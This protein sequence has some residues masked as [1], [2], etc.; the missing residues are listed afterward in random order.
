MLKWPSISRYSLM[1]KFGLKLL[2]FLIYFLQNICPYSDWPKL[3]TFKKITHTYLKEE[4]RDQAG[5]VSIWRS[6]P[7]HVSV[8][9]ALAD[10]GCT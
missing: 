1:K 6:C 9:L 2:L 4:A 5:V 3:L 10:T 8:R 7:I